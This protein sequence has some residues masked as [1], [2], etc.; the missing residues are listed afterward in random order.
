[1]DELLWL[2]DISI[3]LL[4]VIHDALQA[5]ISPPHSFLSVVDLSWALRVSFY[6]P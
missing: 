4:F 3:G 2:P 6:H 5:D 1:M